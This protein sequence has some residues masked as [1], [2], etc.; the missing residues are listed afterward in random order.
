MADPGT[1][2]ARHEE[3]GVPLKVVG[4]GMLAFF[5]ILAIGVGFAG[6]LM[7]IHP[8]APHAAIETPPSLATEPHLQLNTRTDM[9]ALRRLQTQQ[10]TTG[11]T[12][13]INEAMNRIAAR[14]NG[15]YDRLDPALPEAPLPPASQPDGGASL[16][17]GSGR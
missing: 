15:A 3:A 12:L 7:W 11:A 2:A 9:E 17:N 16:P 13:P 5:L 6:L 1:K 8:E 4:L 14:G 10:I